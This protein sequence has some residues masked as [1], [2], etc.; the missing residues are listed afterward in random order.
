[1]TSSHNHEIK[2]GVILVFLLAVREERYQTDILEKN[3]TENNVIKKLENQ[4][5]G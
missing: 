1:M 3:S 5:P 2:L 4:T